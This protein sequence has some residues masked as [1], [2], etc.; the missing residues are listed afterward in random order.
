MLR[1]VALVLTGATR[2]DIPE[3]A[4]LHSHC[5]GNLKSY[6]DINDPSRSS[7]NYVDGESSCL[8]RQ[9]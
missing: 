2:R 1:H 3:D 5:R 4:I 6:I 9:S 7:I 8:R